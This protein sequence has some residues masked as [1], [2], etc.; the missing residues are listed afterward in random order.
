MTC[1]SCVRAIKQSLDGV[2]GIKNVDIDLKQNSVVVD[3]TLPTEDI[4]KRLESTG[5]KAIVRGLAGSLAGVAI[6][7]TGNRDIQGVVRFVQVDPDTCIIDGTV[8]GLNP[9]NHGLFVHETG[10]MSKGCE[11]VG[12][13]YNPRDFAE[14]GD[15]RLYGS[16]GTIRAGK[17]GRASFKL[18]DKIIKLPEIIG[19]SLVLTDSPNSGESKVGNRLVC[20]IIARSSGLFGNTKTICACDGVSLWDEREKPKSV[21]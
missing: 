19:R 6:L 1:D 2:P 13:C 18:E 16:L 8:D 15:T 9:G 11:S 4:H 10:D 14:I 5:R 20:G 3:T 17:D 12:N 21:L 7:D